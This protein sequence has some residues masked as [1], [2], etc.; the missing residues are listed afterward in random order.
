MNETKNCPHCKSEL[1]TLIGE[2]YDYHYCTHCLK[3]IDDLSRSISIDDC[4][5][6]PDQHFVL[7]PIRSGNPQIRKQCNTCGRITTNSFSKNSV[8]GLIDTIAIE[9]K[10]LESEKR[11]F[12]HAEKKRLKDQINELLDS[13]FDSV[14]SK[15][16]SK[17]HGYSAYLKSESWKVK[18]NLVLQRDNYICQSCR[19]TTATEVHH[20]HYR[21]LRNEPLFDLVSVCRRCHEII[22]N[23]DRYDTSDFQI[24]PE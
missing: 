5:K 2:F 10:Q 17:Y 18:R 15:I 19:Q 20:L 14:V 23:L 16:E 24:H 21:H 6:M 22:T 1:K 8:E 4:C 3:Y 11:E 7:H 9:N 13:Q 12:Y